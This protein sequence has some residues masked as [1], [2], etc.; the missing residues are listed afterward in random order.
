MKCP[1]KLPNTTDSFYNND[2]EEELCAWWIPEIKH[3]A[4]FAIPYILAGK[5]EEF[6]SLS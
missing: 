1:F 3:C 5:K 4:M 6:N 2:C